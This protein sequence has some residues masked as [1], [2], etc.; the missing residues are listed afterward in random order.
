MRGWWAV[1]LS[2]PCAVALSLG[3]AGAYFVNGV[4]KPT[5][6]TITWP[7]PL[8]D[9]CNGASVPHV[10]HALKGPGRGWLGRGGSGA[11]AGRDRDGA[12]GQWRLL[13]ESA[14][15]LAHAE[16]AVRVAVAAYVQ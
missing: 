2:A 7:S 12:Q 5:G 8:S 15:R 9:A 16:P 4:G 10:A 13:L 6:V 14:H 3:I 11:A 1:V